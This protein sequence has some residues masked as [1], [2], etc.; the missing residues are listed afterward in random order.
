MQGAESFVCRAF[1]TNK[2]IRTVAVGVECRSVL[3]RLKSRC[4]GYRYSSQLHDDEDILR[5]K[6][7]VGRTLSKLIA[8]VIILIEL[9]APE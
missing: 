4:I 6:N 1:I 9:Q 8:N 5:T 3:S 2:I 7:Y